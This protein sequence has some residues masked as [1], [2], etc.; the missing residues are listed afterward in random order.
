MIRTTLRYGIEEATPRPVALK[1]VQ[2]TVGEQIEEILG[3]G[4]DPA[5]AGRVRQALANPQST[6]EIRCG[7]RTQTATRDM[8]LREL[9]STGSES[10][11]ITVSEPHAGG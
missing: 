11:E 4:G 8:P 1:A 9:L 2:T 6:I 3:R 5:V 7:E 10:L